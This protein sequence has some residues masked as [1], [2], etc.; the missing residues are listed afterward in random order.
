MQSLLLFHVVNEKLN[1]RRASDLPESPEYR[2][3]RE[4]LEVILASI[5]ILLCE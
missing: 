3:T 2:K 4:V 5:H 1:N